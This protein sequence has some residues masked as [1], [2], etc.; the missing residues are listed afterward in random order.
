IEAVAKA[1][2]VP[3][4]GRDLV[5]SLAE[6]I[7][8]VRRRSLGVTR[9]PCVALVEWIDPPFSSGHWGPELVRLAGGVEG[10][11]REG[12][13]SRTL[14]WSE[15]VDWQPEV[16]FLACCGFSVERTLGELPSLQRRPGYAELPAVRSGRVFVA[17]G[18]RYF[19][20][21]GPHLVDSLEQLAHALHPD[22]HP[23]PAG[24]PTLLLLP[25][26]SS[27]EPLSR[28]AT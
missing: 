9:R 13:P 7:E 18:R 2:E 25:P 14:D 5:R 17:D 16:V 28:G 11:G 12:E 26:P 15:L 1:A 21:P 22:R 8:S 23:R 6:R 4:R 10:L 20:R 24:D 3:E 19:S 27:R